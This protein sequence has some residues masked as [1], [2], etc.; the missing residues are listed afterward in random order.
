MNST[1]RPLKPAGV[2]LIA[3][4]AILALLE[5]TAPVAA[6]D[7]PPEPGAQPKAVR[8][9][10][11]TAPG[12]R[13]V[14]LNAPKGGVSVVVFL[15]AECP[16]SNAYSPALNEIAGA[17]AGRTFQVVGV[18]VDPDLTD[19][20][21]A[22]HARDFGLKFPVAC[23]R[24]VALPARLGARVTPEAFVLDDRGQVRYH[25]RIDDQFAAR[26]QRNAAPSTNELRDAV[27]AVLAGAEVAIPYAE[28]VGCPIPEPPREGPTP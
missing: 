5:T 19:A 13:P 10:P 16:I 21:L 7:G 2:R 22:A 12:G 23:D 14:D 9:E 1:K 3:V 11:L 28:A 17:F 15:S 20:D 27:A 6:R 24:H 4:A 18:Y 25:G 8:L 26:R